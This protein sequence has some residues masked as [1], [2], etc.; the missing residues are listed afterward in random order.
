MAT[1][2]WTDMA[3]NP[4]L[5]ERNRRFFPD[6]QLAKYSGRHIAWN[7]EGTCIVAEAATGKELYERLKELGIDP[8]LTV[9]SF[10]P[11]PN[12]SYI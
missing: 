1:E 12:T 4:V 5:F 6:E 8:C 10:V 2:P 7:L 3:F 11:D 9:S